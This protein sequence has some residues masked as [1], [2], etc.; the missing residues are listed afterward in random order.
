M[1]E[2]EEDQTSKGLRKGKRAEV[3]VAAFFE[4]DSHTDPHSSHAEMFIVYNVDR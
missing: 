3:I 4:D 1:E 2:E